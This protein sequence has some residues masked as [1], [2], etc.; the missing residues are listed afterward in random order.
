MYGFQSRSFCVS[1]INKKRKEKPIILFLPIVDYT[2]IEEEEGG[3]GVNSRA[4]HFE[5]M[6]FRIKSK[7]NAND[8]LHI[9]TIICM[10]LV[11]QSYACCRQ[12]C[13][14][15]Y[16]G[17]VCV[18]LCS[19][20][21]VCAL[22]NTQSSITFKHYLNNFFAYVSKVSKVSKLTSQLLLTFL[23]RECKNVIL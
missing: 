9:H 2:F 7:L 15:T 14:H 1:E 16:L 5:K 4:T 20:E 22:C 21:N 3:E 13:L 11:M 12:I 19:T 17:C 10:K 23:K 6:I 8:S 18:H